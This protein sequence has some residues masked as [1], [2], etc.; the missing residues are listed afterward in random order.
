[1]PRPHT[2]PPSPS[3]DLEIHTTGTV[4]VIDATVLPPASAGS[5]PGSVE[6]HVDVTV[7][8]EHL[9]PRRTQARLTVDRAA[10]PHIHPGAELLADLTVDGLVA[11]HVPTTEV[12]R[13]T[14]PV[15]TIET[16]PSAGRQS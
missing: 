12:P 6:L 7:L 13:P 4:V 15:P 10:V 5:L 16:T 8:V 11:L 9:Q 3:Q 14:I 2:V 1:M